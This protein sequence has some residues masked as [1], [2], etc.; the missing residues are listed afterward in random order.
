MQDPTY[1]VLLAFSQSDEA[2]MDKILLALQKIDRLD[3]MNRV[4]DCFNTLI[5]DILQNRSSSI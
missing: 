3:V 1:Y 2:T 5:Q 4:T